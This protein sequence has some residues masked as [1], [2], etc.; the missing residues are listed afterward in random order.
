MR[1][2]GWCHHVTRPSRPFSV[3]ALTLTGAVA[4]VTACLQP[5]QS[6]ADTPPEEAEQ[7]LDA[8]KLQAWKS[9]GWP[10]MQGYCI[11]CHN[12]DFKEAGLDL[13]RFES[14]DDLSA[15]EIKRVVE[16]VRF[17]AMPPEDY[18]TP[19]I[20]E[21][22]QLVAALEETMFS[23]TCDLRPQAGKVTARRLNRSEY[24]NSVRDLFGLDLRPADQF[25]SDEVG[26]GFDNNGD[27]L[28][29]SPMLIEKY[30]QAA[31]TVSQAVLVDPDDL[32]EIDL[33]VPGDQLAI[34]GEP[35]VGS[36]YGRFIDRDA[37]A[38]L[39]LDLPYE[40]EYDI[41]VR[42]GV[43]QKDADPIRVAICDDE[44]LVLAVDELKYFGGGGSGDSMRET[45]T[46]A[47]GKHRL[48]FVPIYD[49]RELKVG[50]DRL[51]VA[52]QMD[53]ERVEAI[54]AKLGQPVEVTRG[55]DDQEYPFMLRAFSVSGPRR[56]PE[57]AFPPKQFE[58]VRDRPSGRPGRYRDV[59]KTATKNLKPLM[60][61]M[62][63]GPVSDDEVRPYAELV[64]Q[65]TDESKSFYR[66]M[67]I[68]VSALLVSPR[69][70]FRVETPSP[71]TKPNEFGDLPL[72][73]HQLATRLAYFLWSSTPD[74]TLLELADR[75]KLKGETLQQQIDRMLRDSRSDALAENFA[76]QW[77]GLRNLAGHDADDKRYP[78]F[79]DDLKAAMNRETQL[80][81]MHLVRNNLSIS[82]FLTADYT[83]ANQALAKY[84]G[85][86][87]DADASDGF[88]KVSLTK[89]PRRGLLSHASILTL[90]ST[91]TRT[92]PV[93]RG[94][95]I[96]E[97]ILGIKAP[98]PP[99]G[100]PDLDET[101]AAAD[102][103]TLREQ[104]ELHRQSPSCAS[105]HRVMDQL[106]F[107]LDDF[108]AVGQ[109]RSEDAGQPIDA[110]GALPDGRSFNGGAE[111]SKMLSETET[112]ALARTLIERLLT[113]AIGRELTPD[114]RCAIDEIVSQ[115]QSDQFRLADII[116]A[117][118][119]SRQFQF[120]T[121]EHA[122][123]KHP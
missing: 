100:V 94:K 54:K 19:E 79:T 42:G 82:E 52:T 50:D 96:L 86:E 65:T 28:S 115:T 46:L 69:F 36:F 83:F 104:L 51:D 99:A 20:E 112:P 35:L 60:R 43:T 25:P 71:E 97:N 29:L 92:S 103:A 59:T 8:A 87:E 91:P 56:R 17:G 55:I 80:F 118:V 48:V 31:E 12:A 22:K 122:A 6:A 74:E 85:V 73:Q 26:G 121:V 39:D 84:Y 1:S 109:F 21:R 72:S 64:K 34:Y 120:Q 88:E 45:V 67:Q 102:N 119:H 9:N 116:A 37:F 15:S 77:L 4:I 75:D 81:F 44:G 110:S 24:N 114:D 66:G 23:A 63:R 62:F 27:V 10:L 78:Q 2:N 101:E 53:P 58:I 98:D 61:Q 32:P 117:V 108:D 18:D 16:M 68:A 57:W 33:D 41:T 30:L 7:T 70:L 76:A 40:G 105:C 106:G 90:T 49:D 3:F 38:W 13:S 11:D 107:G 89:T 95:W 113:F 93:L 5:A 111:L 14:L 47:K 123:A